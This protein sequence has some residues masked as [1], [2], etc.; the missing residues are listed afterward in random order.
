MHITCFAVP[1]SL[2]LILAQPG[3]PVES[4]CLWRAGISAQRYSYK[5]QDNLA[6]L[7]EFIFL[8]CPQKDVAEH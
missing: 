1:D 4:G 7:S 3:L 2:R 6:Y 5:N 8:T